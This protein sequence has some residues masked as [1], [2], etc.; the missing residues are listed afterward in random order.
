MPSRPAPKGSYTAREAVDIA[1]LAFIGGKTNR[2]ISDKAP[3]QYFPALITKA[4]AA[5]LLA[6]CIPTDAALLE[7]ESYKTFLGARRVAV[8]QRLN[9]FLNGS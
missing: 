5:A 8:S 2:Q 7:V 3:A 4:G 1:N 6:P 9:E